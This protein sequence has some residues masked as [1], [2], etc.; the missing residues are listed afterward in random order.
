MRKNEDIFYAQLDGKHWAEDFFNQ[1]V[2]IE[3]V[4]KGG[5]PFYSGELETVFIESLRKH[6]Y[7]MKNESTSNSG[8]YARNYSLRNS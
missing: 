7:R 8:N 2:D 5:Q 1:N 6:Y 3:H 4:I